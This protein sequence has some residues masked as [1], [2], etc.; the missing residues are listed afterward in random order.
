MTRDPG[1][2]GRGP[3]LSSGTRRRRSVERL[4]L[5][6]GRVTVTPPGAANTGLALP[7]VGIEETT[8]NTVWDG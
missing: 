4:G 1:S 3:S 5:D 8:S 2:G 6:P 7:G